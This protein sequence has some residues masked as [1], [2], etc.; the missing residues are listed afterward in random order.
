MEFV[1]TEVYFDAVIELEFP[2][3]DSTV[4][5]DRPLRVL[6]LGDGVPLEYC[7]TA[8]SKALLFRQDRFCV[9]HSVHVIPYSIGRLTFQ[10]CLFNLQIQLL[11]PQTPL[12]IYQIPQLV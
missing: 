7:E 4:F 6:H 9:G 2:Q 3:T 11:L 1:K 8:S 12:H 10:I 5:F